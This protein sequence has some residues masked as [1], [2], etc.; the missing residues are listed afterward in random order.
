MHSIWH[1][2]KPLGVGF[3]TAVSMA[4]GDLSHLKHQLECAFPVH[5]LFCNFAI[6]WCTWGEKERRWG[7]R[8]VRKHPPGEWPFHSP[9]SALFMGFWAGTH[10]AP[11][12]IF[13]VPALVLK[14]HSQPCGIH[15]LHHHHHQLAHQSLFPYFLLLLLFPYRPSLPL[16]CYGHGIPQSFKLSLA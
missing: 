13:S 16:F 9:F 3:K 5:L 2:F 12:K 10:M 6:G 7:E 1:V 15:H 4:M 8:T 11:C 14:P